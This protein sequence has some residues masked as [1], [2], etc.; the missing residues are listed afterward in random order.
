MEI[1]CEREGVGW[2]GEKDLSMQIEEM[3]W[4]DV[5]PA[6]LGLCSQN[7]SMMCQIPMA[8]IAHTHLASPSPPLLLDSDGLDWMDVMAEWGHSCFQLIISLIQ[9][10]TMFLDLIKGC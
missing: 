1:V 9:N 2:G 4:F 5:K 10:H 3:I 8:S 6:R 7:P